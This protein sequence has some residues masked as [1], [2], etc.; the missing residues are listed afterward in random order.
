MPLSNN[1]S[2]RISDPALM[3]FASRVA[4]FLWARP[5]TEIHFVSVFRSGMSFLETERGVGSL[6][7]QQMHSIPEMV[8][9]VLRERSGEV[10]WEGLWDLEG[11]LGGGVVGVRGDGDDRYVLL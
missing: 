2:I 7:E 8:E 5:N 11:V 4:H 1:S 6:V 9:D 3:R 10:E